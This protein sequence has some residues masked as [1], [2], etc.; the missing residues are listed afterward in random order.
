MVPDPQLSPALHAGDQVL[1][2]LLAFRPEQWGLPPFDD[3]GCAAAG[4][5][6]AAA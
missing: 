6:G 3:D 2:S 1:P 5:D 4:E